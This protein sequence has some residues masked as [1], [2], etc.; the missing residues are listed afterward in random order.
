LK[1]AVRVSFVLLMLLAVHERIVWWQLGQ[2]RQ[3]PITVVAQRLT[4]LGLQADGPDRNGFIQTIAPGCPAVFPVGMFALDGG[5]DAR[6]AEFLPV[7]S[8]PLYVYL[9]KVRQNRPQ[10][11][12]TTSW[13][14]ASLSAM[15]GMRPTL[16][17][18]KLVLAALPVSCQRLTSLNWA[19]VSQ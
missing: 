4:A 7:N 3:D 1:T 6:I 9:G 18:T 2:A 16:P 5:E 19:S 14:T 11:H 17:P 15:A 12:P 13:L 10:L 8:A